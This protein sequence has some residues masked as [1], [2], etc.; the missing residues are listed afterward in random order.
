MVKLLTFADNP[1]S[2]LNL[3]GCFPLAGI[4]DELVS[5]EEEARP[6]PA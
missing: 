6:K 1:N 2:P 5:D 3:L 4:E